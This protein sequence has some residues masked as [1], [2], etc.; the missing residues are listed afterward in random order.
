MGYRY[1]ERLPLIDRAPNNDG[2]Y[3]DL[4]TQA[5]K[6]IGCELSVIRAPKK[7]LLK[8]MQT[9]D[10]DFY[11][12]FTFNERRANYTFYIENGLDNKFVAIS[13]ITKPDINHVSELRDQI[14]LIS[15]GGPSHNAEK[16]GAILRP[17]E[18]LSLP[19]AFSLIQKE[20]A[21]FYIYNK[22]SV[23][24][25][26]Q[27]TPSTKIKLHPCCGE[28]IP[29]YLGFSLK[30]NYIKVNTNPHY[31]PQEKI[32][33]DN[34]PH[35]LSKTSK[36]Y[37]LAMSLQELKKAGVINRLYAKYYGKKE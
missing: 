14:V 2:L 29:M 16:Y 13:N 17:V 21:D 24:Y 35:I 9:G 27:Q 15:Q 33:V 34:F 3:F 11:P 19:E 5:A 36:A 30:S 6:S 32:A 12:G 26:L 28:I 10:L 7:R 25:Y 37:Q 18:N 8:M 31:S 20:K 1:S 23:D 22:H 4:Y